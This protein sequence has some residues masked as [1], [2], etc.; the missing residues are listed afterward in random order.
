MTPTAPA[1]PPGAC[2]SHTH[3]IAANRRAYP[4]VPQ[5]GYT[6]PPAPLG[7]LRQHLQH[8]GYSRAVLVQVSVYGTDNRLLLRTLRRHPHHLR[9]VVA[10]HP[11]TATAHLHTLHAA[12]VRGVRV[13]LVHPGGPG[14]AQL[15]QL[16]PRLAPLGWHAELLLDI[17]H[18]PA[19][20]PT[21]ARLPLPLVFAHLGH[22]PA[23]LGPQHPVF[24]R[25]LAFCQRHD[26]WVKLSA[27]YRLAD[28]PPYAPSHALARTLLHARPHRL[29]WGTDWPHVA[30]PHPICPASLATLLTTWLPTAALRQALLVDNPARLYDFAA[31]PPAAPPPQTGA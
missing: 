6:P 23:A 26:S 17:R 3:V 27:P 20:A 29:L 9:G 16:A 14:L 18:L 13:N 10:L 25:F 19:L 28:T 2:D 30:T 5:R 8:H 11:H 31:L 15:A 22:A 7:A 24:R 12:G 1:L 21:L 4:M